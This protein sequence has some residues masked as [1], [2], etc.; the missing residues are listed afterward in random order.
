MTGKAVFGHNLFSDLD[1]K[2]FQSKFLTGYRGPRH[3]SSSISVV[4]NGTVDAAAVLRQSYFRDTKRVAESPS[5][6]TSSLIKRH[7]SIQRKL[8]EV[9]TK[10]GAGGFGEGGNSSNNSQLHGTK[11]QSNY[12]S[13]C[14]TWWD[15]SC[16]RNNGV[17]WSNGCQW[18]DVSCVLR[19][20]FGYQYMGGTREPVYDESSYPSVLDWRTLGVV[21][22]VNSQGACG[23]CWA[24][25]AVETIESANAIATGQLIDL[26]E[27]EVIACDGTCEMCN[28]GW[29][30]NAYEYVMKHGG[31][32]VKT[33]DYNADWLYLVTAVLAGESYDVSQDQLSGYFAQ[34]CP[35]G[36][37]EGDSGEAR[38]DNK[39]GGDH[40]SGDEQQQQY[41]SSYVA[42]TR[43]GKVKGYGYATDRCVC[44]TDGSGCDCD[45]QDEKTAVLNVASYGP[46]AVCLEAS[47]WQ[48]Y[49]GGIMTSD[50]GCSSGFL[51]MNHCVEVVGYAFTDEGS[52]SNGGGGGGSRDDKSHKSGSRDS[53]TREGY[54]I[55]K[56]QWS[57]YWGMGGYAY[58]AMGD[59]TCGIL[60]D[61][62]QVYMK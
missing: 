1:P 35:A 62:T 49:E 17:K 32:P 33:S 34:T 53:S 58:L 7:P 61:M 57:T 39:N 19:Y 3:S 28:G 10:Y 25:T 52:S 54:W 37:R 44:Y 29:P 16:Y 6:V 2:E 40:H 26:D 15:I 27:E 41:A 51:D 56:N 47:L 36:V 13:R 24:I 45:N 18:W 20:I 8:D 38:G 11:F 14:N 42:S 22:D 5:S 9:I 46:A 12:G 21:T 60:N 30:Q 23:A 31:L 43:Y 4:G 59:N 50:I 55:V 48:N